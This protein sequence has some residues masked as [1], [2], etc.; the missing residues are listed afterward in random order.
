MKHKTLRAYIRSA[1]YTTLSLSL[2]TSSLNVQACSSLAITDTKGDVYHGRTLELAMDMPSWITY[3]PKGTSFQK[4]DAKGKNSINYTSKYEILGVTTDAV[5]DGD[6]HNMFEGMNSAGLSFSANMV[7]KIYLNPVPDSENK[8][9]IPVTSLGE[10]ALSLFSTVDE[11]KQAVEHNYFWLPTLKAFGGA[12]APIHFAFYDKK[13]GSIVV[14]A[15]NGKFVVY[16]NPTKVLT[17]SPEFPWHLTNL[18]NYTQLNNVDK[19]TAKLGNMDLVQPDSGIA[20]ASLPSSDTAVG[21][22][23]RGVYYTTY[24]QKAENS[25]QA[26]N[27]LSHIMNRFDRTKD[28]TVDKLSE[29]GQMSELS[30]EYT[31]WTSLED[32]SRGTMHIRGYNDIN[33]QVFSFEQFKQSDKPIFTQINLPLKK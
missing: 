1:L 25:V 22:F 17:N 11:V 20:T 29:S 15:S 26:M 2:L 5:F 18:N 9:S 7:Q 33:Y 16:D 6:N 14:E 32:L 12:P 3:Y 21:R 27:T 19:S 8:N 28:I 24:A 23:I 4:I 13:G 30:S 31:V 10:W